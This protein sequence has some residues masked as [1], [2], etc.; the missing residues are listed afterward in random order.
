MIGKTAI[1]TINYDAW[2]NTPVIDTK[3]KG[4]IVKEVING[5]FLIKI[6]DLTDEF[7]VEKF[8]KASINK[9]PQFFSCKNNI[10]FYKKEK[11]EFNLD[12]TDIV[13]DELNEKIIDFF[14]LYGN[15]Y[16]S[17][18]YTKYI[19]VN[20]DENI[21]EISDEENDEETFWTSFS[22]KNQMNLVYY[23]IEDVSKKM[24]L[25]NNE[26]EQMKKLILTNIS[27]KLFNKANII[28]ENKKISDFPDMF[29]DKN[30]RMFYTN[31]NLKIKSIK[32]SRNMN[33]NNDYVTVYN[34][35]RIPYFVAEWEKYCQY[36][37]TKINDYKN[38]TSIIEPPVNDTNIVKKKIIIN[39]RK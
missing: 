15:I 1:S 38:K 33:K 39:K 21:D 14:H 30:T 9:F 31:P 27:N 34:I 37:E 36:L 13:E 18:D 12:L 29:W 23:Y 19:K 7:W 25:T 11:K 3:K 26:S 6:K 32:M 35:N 4:K 28:I 2:M 17:N 8:Q 20:T 16:S 22:K 24:K 10:L 5:I